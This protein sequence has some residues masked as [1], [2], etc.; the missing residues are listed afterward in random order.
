MWLKIMLQKSKTIYIIEET[1]I[2]LI[3]EKLYCTILLRILRFCFGKNGVDGLVSL[4]LIKLYLTLS[5]NT[6]S[7]KI[8]LAPVV[9]P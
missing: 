5:K 6:F 7:F 2:I 1:G 4:S 8:F 3:L 9:F